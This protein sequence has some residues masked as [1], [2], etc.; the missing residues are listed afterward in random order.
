MNYY[1]EQPL[2]MKINFIMALKQRILKISHPQYHRKNMQ[3]LFQTIRKNSYPPALLKKLM[4]GSH[5][6]NL[7]QK[8]TETNENNTECKFSSINYV[9]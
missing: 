8:N 9:G 4:F 7:D 2:K 3:D 1:S 6:P 5:A